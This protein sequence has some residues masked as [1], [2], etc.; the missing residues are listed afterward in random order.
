MD[1]QEWKQYRA[2]V[3]SAYEAA[4][5]G[6]PWGGARKALDDGYARWLRETPDG[7]AQKMDFSTEVHSVNALYERAEEAFTAG[8]SIERAIQAVRDGY[9]SAE[10]D[11]EYREQ[12]E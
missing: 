11:K 6:L 2:M 12:V 9:S 5:A 8:I 4:V 7:S 3:Q 1:E 10:F